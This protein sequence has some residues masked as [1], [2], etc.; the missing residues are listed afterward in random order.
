[1][2]Y[3]FLQTFGLLLISSMVMVSCD[4]DDA[5]RTPPEIE[6]MEILPEPGE[7]IICGESDDRVIPLKGGEKLRMD[8]LITDDRALSQLKVDVHPNFDCHGHRTLSTEDWIV[9]D[10]IDL[11]GKAVEKSLIYE[12]PEMV[13]AGNYH[14][15]LR[16]VD[17]AGNTTPATDFWSVTLI[18]PLDS[19]PPEFSVI[20]PTEHQLVFNRGD[21]FAIGLAVSDNKPF[22]FGGNA[23]I[24]LSYRAINS[25]NVFT[26]NVVD[27]NSDQLSKET[28][29]EF[30]IPN[31]LVRGDYKFYLEVRD[32]VNNQ[33]TPLVFDVEIK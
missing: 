11:E 21:V 5:D 30:E 4:K 33:A 18:N 8:V 13:T 19:I 14:L 20:S 9:L 2:R 31:S 23:R 27:L 32:G 24:E 6:F 12:V 7:G 17:Q 25:N 10:L 1:M 26:A 22:N 15:Q 3:Y 16:V 29:I 28:G